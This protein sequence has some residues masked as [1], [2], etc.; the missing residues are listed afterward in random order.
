MMLDSY[1]NLAT[2]YNFIDRL[3]DIRF[4]IFF[5]HLVLAYFFG[6]PCKHRFNTTKNETSAY[7]FISHLAYYALFNEKKHW[8]I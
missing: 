3:I 5:D 8:C 2:K 7:I 4:N 6:P 1:F